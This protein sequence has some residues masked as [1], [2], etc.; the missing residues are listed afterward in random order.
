MTRPVQQQPGPAVHGS[1][2]RNRS[3]NSGRVAVG[4]VVVVVGRVVVVVVV[5]GAGSVAGAGAVA[6]W[7]VPED[8][9]RA[10]GASVDA[11]STGTGAG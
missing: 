10:P 8:A 7:V 3:G 11:A 6:A 2:N 5:G 4:G 1:G 9:R